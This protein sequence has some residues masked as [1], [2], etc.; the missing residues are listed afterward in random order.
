[1]ADQPR[2]PADLVNLRL[3]RR[4]ILRAGI[5][6]PASAAFLAA[7]GATATP[8]PIVTA[9]PTPVPTAPPATPAPTVAA[10]AA[11]PSATPSAPPSAAAPSATASPAP[12]TA[13]PAP[14]TVSPAPSASAENFTGITI[15]MASSPPD[16]AVTQAAATA[17]MAAT[18]GTATVTP[19]PYAERALDFA[20]AIV[21][22]DPHYDVYFASKDFVALFGSRLYTDISTLGIDTSDFVPIALKQLSDNGKNY[23]LPLFADQEFFIYNNNYWKQAGLDPT[24]VPTTWDEMYALTP[25]LLKANGGKAQAN[26]TPMLYPS[27]SYWLIYYNSF[28][29]PFLSDD[30]T[31]ALF[32]NDSGIA[33]WDSIN[34]GFK[35]GFFGQAG[36]NA[37]ADTDASLLFN[38]GIAA[39]EIGLVEFFSEAQSGDVKDFKATIA[40]ADVSAAVMPGVN[41]GTTG[42]IIVTEGLG[43]SQFS[44][45]KEA[46]VSFMKFATSPDFQ[47]QLAITGTQGQINP[48]SRLSVLADPAVVAAFTL[49]PI[50]A[51]QG[52][53]QLQ[54]PGVPYPDLDK[55]F[56]LGLSNMYKGTWTPQQAQMETVS[57]TKKLIQTWLTS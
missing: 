8:S 34:K 36:I 15:N 56:G 41:A 7:C 18:G 27:T 57:A 25:S 40:K 21:N 14:A 19:V 35:A 45:N 31:Q 6:L 3:S 33:A 50:L 53:G 5:M 52:A 29:L 55:V 9:A 48:P 39:S 20:A 42:S 49:A 11:A 54:W 23:A 46:A 28:N 26:A 47:K 1:V 4:Q 44:K 43:L 38:Q 17:W 2:T 22:Q 10:T 16:L 37:P 32:D 13:S 51:K 12:A 24:N 30:R